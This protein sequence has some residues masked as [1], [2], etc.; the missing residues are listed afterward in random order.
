MR[1]SATGRVA[2]WTVTMA[3][4]VATTAGVGLAQPSISVSI[5]GEDV[6]EGQTVRV[7]NDPD[8]EI[9]IEADSAL[10]LV[11]VRVDG[12][13]R[14][15]FEPGTES[16]SQTVTLDVD[17]GENDVRV[18]AN[19][20]EVTTFEA[21][22]L[23]DNAGPFIEYT[24]PFETPEMRPPPEDT[25]VSDALVT[26]SGNLVDDTGVESI[27]I[28]RRFRYEYAGTTDTDRAFYEID[29]P[30]ESF[31]QELFLGDGDNDIS[32][33]YTDEMGNVRT[34]EFSLTVTDDSSPSIDLTVPSRTGA[35][36]VRLRGTVKDNVKIRTVEISGPGVNKEVVTERSPEPN[37]DRLAV[38]INE[39][40]SLEEGENRLVVAATDNSGNTERREVTVVYDRNVEPRITFDPDR[41]GFEG[42]DLVVRGRVDRGRIADVTLEAIDT[43]S[44]DVVD[45]VK[46]YSGDGTNRVDIDDSLSVA[47]GETR[48]RVLVTDV[49]GN[50]HEDSFTVDPTT[51]TVSLQGA[52]GATDGTP[53]ATPSGGDT[54]TA[55]P[56]DATP[57]PTSTPGDGT[58]GDASASTSAAETAPQADS[59]ADSG[60]EVEASADGPGFTV[61][62]SVLAIVL[63]G[64]RLL[65]RG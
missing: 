60:G 25:T 17:N 40:M 42:G 48:I 13:I 27:E 19:A 54:P 52:D 34:H 5:D 58:S 38:E 45:I 29:D 26:L 22:I 31:S 51:E 49:D 35:P 16:F 55:S 8:V 61:G 7:K 64:M 33:R 3:V 36:E 56:G 41:T 12:E 4:I 10:E 9:A 32:V 53:T 47:D 46:V 14:E 21:T 6:S 37:R 50:Q 24:T 62:V 59:D 28:E 15:T 2:I 65:A 1:L 11:E 43:A 39:V 63:V 30:G 57:S 20:D 18:I 44:E 23:K